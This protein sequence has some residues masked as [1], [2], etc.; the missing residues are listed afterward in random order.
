MTRILPP[1]IPIEPEAGTDTPRAGTRY[2][3]I[4]A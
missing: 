2:G 1:G 3:K 4:T